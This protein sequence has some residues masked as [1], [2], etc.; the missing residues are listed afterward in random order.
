MKSIARHLRRYRMAA[1]RRTTVNHMFAAAVASHDRYD[2]TRVRE[3]VAL[4]G[5]DPDGHLACAY[6]GGAAETRDLTCSPK[7][8]QS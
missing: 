1:S 6:C 7:L 5:N 4:L 8:Y 2:E 3:A